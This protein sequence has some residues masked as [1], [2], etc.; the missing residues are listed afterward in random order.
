[1]KRILK[2]IYRIFYTL[3]K[4][5]SGIKFNTDSAE[6]IVWAPHFFT[7]RFMH[8]DNFPKTIAIYKTLLENNKQC[9][10]YTG[11]DIG[12]FYNKKIF[13]IGSPMYNV[14]G[15]EDYVDILFHIVERLE[16]QKNEVFP[17]L[18]QI[19]FWENKIFM[20]QKFEELNIRAPKSKIISTLN[21]INNFKLNYPFLLK[22]PHSCSANGVH[23][24][25][26]EKSLN[27]FML[28]NKL[29]SKLIFQ[30][31][32]NIKRDLR[33]ILVGN[34]IVLHYWRINLA[35]EWRPTSTGYGSKVDFVSFPEKWRDYIISAFK[36]LNL[37]TGAFDIAWENDDIN[38]EPYILEVSPFYQP[39]PIPKFDLDEINY[40]EWKKSFTF[41]N[42]NNYNKAM[43][44]ILFDIQRKYTNRILS[45]K[46]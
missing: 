15:F 20:H 8:G 45:E 18:N 27:N 23:K 34:E 3:L 4:F 5:K 14:Y 32:L 40:G 7:L 2:V 24:I 33:V 28:K 10:I 26:D 22:E 38:T 6:Y 29:T 35:D 19:K 30:E 43:I 46:K 39:N 42:K 44:D 41:S 1:M 37:D 17:S 16:S 25:N 21:D 12:K 36:K 9:S 11:K 13:I 31:L